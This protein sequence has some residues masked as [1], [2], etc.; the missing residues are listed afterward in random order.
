MTSHRQAEDSLYIYIY[1]HMI[2]ATMENNMN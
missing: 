1:T 2:D